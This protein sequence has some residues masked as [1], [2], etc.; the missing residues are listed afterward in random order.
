M[1]FKYL[2]KLVIM[3]IWS[4]LSAIPMAGAGDMADV[5]AMMD[6]AGNQTIN[7]PQNKKDKNAEETA[8]IFNSREYQRKLQVQINALKPQ[9]NPDPENQARVSRKKNHQNAYLMP[10]ERIFLFV[11]SSMPA[12]TL[13][14]F[15]ADLDK[16]KDP[17]IFMVMR[18]FVGGVRLIKPTLKFID[19]ILIKDPNCN[20]VTRKCEAYQA[21]INIDPALFSKYGVQTVPAIVYARGVNETEAGQGTTENIAADAYLVSGDISLD[22]ALEVILKE[23]KSSQIDN[24]L[25]K[26]RR[27]F[28]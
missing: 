11:S 19:S 13:K 2:I 25:K 8:E 5:N 22:Y 12:A 21:N 15:A 9:L 27:G 18:G 6:A 20:P 17:N 24:I 1:R 23:S 7:I 4:V 3:L 10:D 28:Y 16:L 14:N 26:L